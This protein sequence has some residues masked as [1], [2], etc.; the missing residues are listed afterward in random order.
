[1]SR[2]V[3]SRIPSF[4]LRQAGPDLSPEVQSLAKES[5]PELFWSGLIQV[6]QRHSAKGRDQ[7]ASGLLSWIVEQGGSVPEESRR[8]AGRELAALLGQGSFGQ[9]AETIFQR[10]RREVSDPKLIAPM[11]LGSTVFQLARGAALGRMA[12]SE[13]SLLTR[14]LGARL[15]A[16]LT[17]FA[18]EVPAFA[19]SSRGLH[20]MEG[21][22]PARSL[23]Q[24]LLSATLT[25]GALKTFGALGSQA[26]AATGLGFGRQAFAQASMFTGMLASHR[27]EAAAGL[28][29]A[30]EQRH[31]IADILA[32]MLSLSAGIRLGRGLLGE[33]FTA[34]EREMTVRTQNSAPTP[35]PLAGMGM[36]PALAAAGA[37]PAPRISLLERLGREH[38]VHMESDGEGN[39]EARLPIR[40]FPQTAPRSVPKLQPQLVEENPGEACPLRQPVGDFAR[41]R[42]LLTEESGLERS[43]RELYARFVLDRVADLPIVLREFVPPPNIASLPEALNWFCERFGDETPGQSYKSLLQAHRLLPPDGELDRMVAYD[44]LVLARTA[45]SDAAHYLDRL[46]HLNG[47]AYPALD[48]RAAGRDPTRMRPIERTSLDDW[49]VMQDQFPEL[50]SEVLRAAYRHMVKERVFTQ[51]IYQHYQRDEFAFAVTD[52]GH[53][54]QGTA[55]AFAFHHE[56]NPRAFAISPHYRSGT[57]AGLWSELQGYDH[58][59]RDYIRQQL[60]RGTDTWSRGRQTAS[61]FN[62]LERNILPAHSEVGRNLSVAVG[63]A[64]AL[65]QAG[66]RDAVVYAE[67]GDGSMALSDFHEAM[68]G[69]AVMGFSTRNLPV[70]IG[71]LDNQM[72]ISV[73]P[74]SGRALSDLQSYAKAFGAKFYTCDGNDFIDVYQTY[75]VAVSAAKERQ[76]PVLVWVQNL[77]RLNA[78]SS[79]ANWPFDFKQRDPLLELSESMVKQGLLGEDEVLRRREVSGSP[80]FFSG[81]RLGEIGEAAKAE[82]DRVWS[83]VAAEPE[84]TLV[85][86]SSD[87]RLPYAQAQE[88]PLVGRPTA[89]IINGAIRAALRDVIESNPLT[90]VNGQDTGMKGGVMQATAGLWELFPGRVTD[91]PINEPAIVGIGLGFAMH[92][93]AVAFPEIQFGDYS[94]SAL[95]WMIKAGNLL[96]TSGGSRQANWNLR[97]PVEPGIGGAVYHSTPLEGLYAAIPGLTI[98][99][100]STSRDAYGLIRSAAEYAGPVIFFEPKALYRQAI[101]D[102]FPNEPSDKAELAAYTKDI[103]LRR[104][105]PDLPKDFRVPLGQAAVRREGRDLTIVTWGLAHAEALK[106]LDEMVAR[107][108]DVELI[109]LRT[110]VPPDMA[111]VL[112]SVEKTGRLLVVHQDRVFASLGREIQGQVIEALPERGVRSKVLGMEPVPGIPQH[113]GMEHEVMVTGKKILAEALRIVQ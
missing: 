18:A 17:G 57:L 108:I 5:D 42:R 33:G 53:E 65:Q 46:H 110:I 105:I 92:P 104:A 21:I 45:K 61:H 72:A 68:T 112:K 77:P 22:Q 26:Y 41:A 43:D 96:W 34:W 36:T 1:M 109:D 103:S 94:T 7:E 44:F 106:V 89:V 32:T 70:V 79:A 48:A 95:H 98:V 58:F 82:L 107:G 37:V 71:V 31:E 27:L 15:G 64:R 60:S 56:V 91:A 66:H 86:M 50:T 54:I 4:I 85:E 35:R 11:I 73:E 12:A 19:L 102:A 23:G 8:K 113:R 29:P 24:D 59:F 9:H 6:A 16:G 78:H 25:L 52:A 40:T 75:R 87:I 14:G 28:R 39:P 63:Y 62:D 2:E 30:D 93:G 49:E 55:A 47:A 51:K 111:T 90:W 81:H 97:L 80:S 83:E 74:A 99:A 20:A 3:L 69:A 84:P 76:M 67:L 100:P 88:P 10:V 101:G 13:A 38:S